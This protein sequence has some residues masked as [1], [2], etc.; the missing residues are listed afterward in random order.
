MNKVK[1]KE[2]QQKVDFGLNFFIPLLLTF[3]IYW[4][5]LIW[6]L[7]DKVE[8]HEI[9]VFCLIEEMQMTFILFDGV[10]TCC[11]LHACLCSV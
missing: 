4:R 11:I 9:D 6:A 8:R 10:D 5:H 2:F 1:K 3:D 7:F